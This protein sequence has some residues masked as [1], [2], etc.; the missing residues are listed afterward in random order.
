M[1]PCVTCDFRLDTPLSCLLASK[2]TAIATIVRNGKAASRLSYLECPVFFFFFFFLEFSSASILILFSHE[3][4]V[5]FVAIP[6]CIFFL[7]CLWIVKYTAAVV[8]PI[9]KI[10]TAA[11]VAAIL[12]TASVL[13]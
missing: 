7:R 12:D 13:L 8:A 2:Q 10:A 4:S 1:K 9:I 5:T 6:A 11:N 3:C